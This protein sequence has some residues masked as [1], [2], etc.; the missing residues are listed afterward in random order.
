MSSRQRSPWSNASLSEMDRYRRI[1]MV[2]E[3]WKRRALAGHVSLHPNYHSAGRDGLRRSEWVV[4]QEFERRAGYVLRAAPNWSEI[5]EQFR[6][7]YLRMSD[8]QAYEVLRLREQLDRERAGLEERVRAAV[9]TELSK[10]IP[11]GGHD[12]N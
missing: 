11:L 1:A 5:S 10:H 4:A 2:T 12:G 9:V 7:E 8:P 6:V 3:N